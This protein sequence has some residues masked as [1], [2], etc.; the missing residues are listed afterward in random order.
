MSASKHII[1]PKQARSK[2]TQ[3]K[4]LKALHECLEDKFF[5]HISIQELASKA[6][7]SVGSYYRRFKNKES[8]LPMLYEDFGQDLLA[9]VD[10]FEAGRYDSL[11]H[12]VNELV[13]QTV[14]FLA[15]RISVF[16]TLHLNSRLHPE[17]L[18]ETEINARREVYKRLADTILRYEQQISPAEKREAAEMVVHTVVNGCM[19]KILYPTHTPA[20]ASRLKILPYAEQLAAMQ[21]AYLTKAP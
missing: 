1:E 2:E 10:S 15:Q 5:E 9:F 3:K 14:S 18:S 8:L 21:I 16:R 17:M 4:L 7:V 11:E 12:T 6:Q 13:E 20:I 19:D